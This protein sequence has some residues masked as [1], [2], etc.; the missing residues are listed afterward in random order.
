[1]TPEV[2]P[3]PVRAEVSLLVVKAHSEPYLH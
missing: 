3:F 1:M 2:G